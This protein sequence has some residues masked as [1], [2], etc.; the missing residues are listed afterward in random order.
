M[1]Y[2]DS[3]DFLRVCR[4]PF[5]SWVL[6][7]FVILLRNIAYDVG[8]YNGIRAM[9]LD[10]IVILLRN[11]AYDVGLY[12]GIRAMAIVATPRVLDILILVG[13]GTRIMGIYIYISC[14]S[15]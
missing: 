10:A 2:L 5:Y 6:T 1:E 9:G 8:L 11:I 3:I 15:R 13:L 14:V 12:N 4:R 7:R